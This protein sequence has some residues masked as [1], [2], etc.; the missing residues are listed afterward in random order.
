MPEP[1][2]DVCICGR[3]MLRVL[4]CN[5]D[6]KPGIHVYWCAGCGV[7]HVR[8]LYGSQDARYIPNPKVI[9]QR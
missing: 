6:Y 7:M 4:N 2:P 3:G 8:N 9:G 5:I 1:D